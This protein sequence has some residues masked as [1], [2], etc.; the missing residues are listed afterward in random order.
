MAYNVSNFLLSKS[1][2]DYNIVIQNSLGELMT[3]KTFNI[4]NIF[5]INNLVKIKLKGNEVT[6]LDFNT[7]VEAFT[8]LQILKEQWTTARELKPYLIDKEVVNYVSGK[9]FSNIS[10]TMSVLLAEGGYS[11]LYIENGIVINII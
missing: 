10:M 7:Q 3:I 5:S 9:T 11:T 1:S 4:I 2:S 8:A 6:T